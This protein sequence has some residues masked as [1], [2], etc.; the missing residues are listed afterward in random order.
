MDCCWLDHPKTNSS[1]ASIRRPTPEHHPQSGSGA[2]CGDANDS[3]QATRTCARRFES[4]GLFY[5][6]Y[7]YACVSRAGRSDDAMRTIF[8]AKVSSPVLLMQS[9][10]PGLFSEGGEAVFLNSWVVLNT[11]KTAGRYASK[12]AVTSFADSLR[13]ETNAKGIRMLSVFSGR[14]ATQGQKLICK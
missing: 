12:H 7:A 4:P 1:I 11:G 5:Q 6:A 13:T 10:L 8:E 9:L 3:A 14:T 2:N